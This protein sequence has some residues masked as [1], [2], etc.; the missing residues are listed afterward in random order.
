LCGSTGG[1]A[2]VFVLLNIVLLVVIGL[3]GIVVLCGMVVL[4]GTVVLG[5]MAGRNRVGGRLLSNIRTSTAT[6]TIA[7]TI[8]RGVV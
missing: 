8:N 5:A 6:I 4:C 2:E 1:V 7:N 3:L